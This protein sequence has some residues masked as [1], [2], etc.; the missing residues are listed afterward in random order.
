[1]REYPERQPVVD[2]IQRIAHL[3]NRLTECRLRIDELEEELESTKE[4][5]ATC[6]SQHRYA[7]KQNR[8]LIEENADLKGAIGG[9]RKVHGELKNAASFALNETIGIECGGLIPDRLSVLAEEFNNLKIRL[10]NIQGI[11]NE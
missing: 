4:E 10:T 5:L 11:L 8:E 9:W 3:Y 6:A 7:A 2:E 1:M